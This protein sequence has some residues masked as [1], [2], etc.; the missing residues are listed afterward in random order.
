MRK[1]LSPLLVSIAL[2]FASGAQAQLVSNHT[3]TLSGPN[4]APPNSSTGT[5]TATLL[6]NDNFNE[7]RL[8]VDF[9]GLIYP[10]TIAHIHCCGPAPETA[11]AATQ[12]PTFV[13]FPAGVTSGS[14][15]RTFNL[16]DAATYNPAFITDAGGTVE[17]AR[18]DFV[19]G[20]RTGEA[21]LN[22]HSTVFPAGE[23]RGFFVAAPI[24]EPGGM[25]MWA[26][27]LIALAGA[28]RWRGRSHSQQ[29]A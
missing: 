13:E 17:L 24:P 1:L 19:D 23:I 9:S 18:A 12:V 2:G 14:Y 16:L 22:I 20:I 10:T 7:M 3:A 5:G 25:A 21:Y 28:S 26:L 6:I 27:G 11:I 4:E 29:A 8:R 15:D